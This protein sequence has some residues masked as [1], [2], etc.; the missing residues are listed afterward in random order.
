MGY[1][2]LSKLKST[3]HIEVEVELDELDLTRAESR[4]T[5]AEIKQKGKGAVLCPEF[6][7]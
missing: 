6:R 1:G 2:F 5:Y 3:P 4:V 7:A